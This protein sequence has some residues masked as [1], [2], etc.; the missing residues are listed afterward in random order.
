MPRLGSLPGQTWSTAK[1]ILSSL[2]L[3][4]L[5][6]PVSVTKTCLAI[7][8]FAMSSII[9]RR[10]TR[11]SLT[12]TERKGSGSTSAS[13]TSEKRGGT[14]TT[15]EIE[16]EP[17]CPICQ[18]TVG[19]RSP[20]GVIEIWNKLPC[21][22]RFGSDCIK[23]Y[24]K[25]VADDRPA[26]PICRQMA[27]HRCGHPVLPMPASI[28]SQDVKKH[29]EP[30]AGD[31]VEAMKNSNCPYCRYK[32]SLVPARERAKKRASRGWRTAAG[33]LF[34]LA[35][36][37]KRVVGRNRNRPQSRQDDQ[38]AIFW[39]GEDG[40]WVDPF[41]RPRDPDW[42]LWWD[43]QATSSSTPEGR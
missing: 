15:V 14:A 34:T 1:Q 33:W 35:T 21:G 26:C 39:R 4:P 8:C 10:K 29:R 42:E 23:Q 36:R 43:A 19:T 31:Q 7:A 2:F 37:P 40:P 22:H 9:M 11:Q 25:I 17:P 28:S 3:A 6:I 30:S 5:T 20:E 24:L 32:S 16:D 38:T 18:E 12:P 13:P 41:P 27:Y